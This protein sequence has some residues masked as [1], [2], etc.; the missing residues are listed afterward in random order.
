M[1]R[2]Y[3]YGALPPPGLEWQ[4][5]K[6]ARAIKFVGKAEAI[7]AESKLSSETAQRLR[8]WVERVK[9]GKELVDSDMSD[10]EIVTRCV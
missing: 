6:T 2:K 1:T 5:G 4:I 8:D 7:L 10:Q 9:D 3:A